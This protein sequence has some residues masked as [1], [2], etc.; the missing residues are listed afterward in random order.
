MIA[1]LVIGYEGKRVVSNHTGLGNYARNLLKALTEYFPDNRYRVYVP[2]ATDMQMP[3]VTF[4]TPEHPLLGSGALWRQWGEGRQAE[5]D[6]CQVF[7]GLSN[8]LPLDLNRPERH[9]VKIPIATVVTIHDL[10]FR[11]HPQ[12]YKPIDRAIY[13]YKFSHAARTATRVIACSQCTKRDLMELYGIDPSKID[14]IYQG[15]DPQ[16]NSQCTMHNSQLQG[17]EPYIVAVG[18]VEPRKNQLLAVKALR[19]LPREIKLKIVGRRTPYAREIDTYAAHYGL[20][21]RIQW[22]ERV[23]WA[24][25]P[26]LYAN[27]VFATYTSRYEGFGIPIVE[28]LASGVPVV[29]CTG[30]CLEEAGGDG[31]LYVNP[32]DEDQMV[33][34]CLQLLENPQLRSDLVQRGRSHISAFTPQNLA[35][36]TMDTYYHALSCQR[37]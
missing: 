25:L 14:V 26:S 11:R 5:K 16:F 17:D 9:V 8:E 29:A 21:D 31:A 10:I 22:L 12:G 37:C 32:D 28:A 4:V 1:P 13:D 35:K 2:G 7:H 18:T 19:G 20:T 34:A 15:C 6:G 36:L 23:P 30:S 33:E 27:A 24:E 3:G